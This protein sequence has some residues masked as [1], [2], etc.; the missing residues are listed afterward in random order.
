MLNG[1]CVWVNGDPPIP[2]K[3][4]V[5][6]HVT[7]LALSLLFCYSPQILAPIKVDPVLRPLFLHL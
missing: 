4:I 5:C 7:K 3:D 2:L 6:G 1:T